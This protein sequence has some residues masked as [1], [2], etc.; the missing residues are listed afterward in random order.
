MEI[1]SNITYACT[2]KIYRL[3]RSLSLLTQITKMLF[4]RRINSIPFIC[5]MSDFISLC[6]LN[7]LVQIFFYRWS[8]K[9]NAILLSI[10]IIWCTLSFEDGYYLCKL[11]SK[12]DLLSDD[13]ENFQ[14]IE[15][16][17]RIGLVQL[18]R[19]SDT[20]AHKDL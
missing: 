16:G 7:G 20:L 12:W 8:F 9:K 15:L 4:F 18:S 10:Y 1:L 6:W 17:D 14:M 3:G 2:W 11:L 5:L 19:V 13:F